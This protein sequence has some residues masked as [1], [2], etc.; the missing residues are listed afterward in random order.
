METMEDLCNENESKITPS[1]SV[2]LWDKQMVN[3]NGSVQIHAEMIKLH[4]F[5]IL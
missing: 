2:N 5:L 1:K 3:A 4:V